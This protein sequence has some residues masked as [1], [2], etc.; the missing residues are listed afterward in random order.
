MSGIDFGD[1][2]MFLCLKHPDKPGERVVFQ[3]T[4]NKRIRIVKVLG[5]ENSRDAWVTD[6]NTVKDSIHGQDLMTAANA[7]EHLAI[8]EEMGW[9]ESQQVL[10]GAGSIVPGVSA[11][12][13]DAINRL[14][15]VTRAELLED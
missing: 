13:M 1:Y 5:S 10:L 7:K 15:V 6:P 8:L 4:K 11:A 12:Q 9:A 3:Y 14:P 2:S